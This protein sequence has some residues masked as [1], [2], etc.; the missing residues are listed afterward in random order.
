MGEEIINLDAMR[1]EKQVIVI[2]NKKIDTSL[3]SFGIILKLI[4]KM[5]DLGDVEDSSRKNTKRMLSVFGEIIDDILKESDSTID[6]KW[7][8]KHIG[9]FQKMILIDK[10]ITPLLD[11]VTKSGKGTKKK[12]SLM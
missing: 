10:V 7:I 2:A 5:E 12:R 6:D 3:I 11:N 8:K 4:D 9:G 1:P